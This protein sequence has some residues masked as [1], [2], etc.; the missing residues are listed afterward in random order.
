[1]KPL[2][3]IAACVFAIL[4]LVPLGAPVGTVATG[5]MLA[6]LFSITKVKGLPFIKLKR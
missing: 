5:I 3:F 6:A 1:M 4:L 2:Y